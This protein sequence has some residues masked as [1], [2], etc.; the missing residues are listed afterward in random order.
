MRFLLLI[1]FS[2]F[3][4]SNTAYSAVSYSNISTKPSVEK[5]QAKKYKK[6]K[7]KQK[8]KHKPNKFQTDSRGKGYLGFGIVFS[9]L[10]LISLILLLAF[11]PNFF[12]GFLIA[13]IMF[14]VLGIG[15]LIAGLHFNNRNS[16]WNSDYE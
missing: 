10:F 11:F 7:L 6:L 4:A 14:F 2:S 13:C 1:L 5:R 9:S 15:T 8:L 16:A 12:L 3:F